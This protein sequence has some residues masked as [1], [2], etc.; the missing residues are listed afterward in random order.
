ENADFEETVEAVRAAL[1]NAAVPVLL[2]DQSGTGFAAVRRTLQDPESPWRQAL[3][4]QVMDA[5][6]D[7]ELLNRYLETQELDEGTLGKLLPLAIS[8]GSLIPV[9]LCN[10]ESGK[11][12]PEVLDFL[13]QF[14]P[15]VEEKRFRDASGAAV[16][17]DPSGEVLAVVFNVKT[18]PHVG[19]VCLARVL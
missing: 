3:L 18:D 1:G 2:P 6:E 15:G 13:E 11:G 10:P 16:A 5:C 17:P 19:K 14:G 12:V 7:E 4:D 9:L 8:K